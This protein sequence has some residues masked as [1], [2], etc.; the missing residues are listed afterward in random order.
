[1][2]QGLGYETVGPAANAHV[3]LALYRAEPIDLVLLD[4]GLCGP[5][6]GLQ[7]TEQLL[8]HSPV[9]LVFLTSF[10]DEQTF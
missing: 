2:L 8:A 6:H 10:R 1:M 9:P 7:L 4:I 3:A 5:T